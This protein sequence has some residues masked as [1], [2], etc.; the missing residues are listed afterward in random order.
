MVAHMGNVRFAAGS[1]NL[2]DAE[3][4]TSSMDALRREGTSVK[5]EGFQILFRRYLGLVLAETH[6]AMANE[7][8]DV[9]SFHPI[10]G[11]AHLPPTL[12][13]SLQSR[14]AK[15]RSY[16]LKKKETKSKGKDE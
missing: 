8:M 10:Q 16:R 2:R 3:I 7:Y 9:M 12:A 15:L 11:M 14:A 1:R 4:L 6:P 5:R 13:A